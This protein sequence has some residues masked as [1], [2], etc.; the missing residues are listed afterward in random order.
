MRLLSNSFITQD[1]R[2]HR[3]GTGGTHHFEEPMYHEDTQKMYADFAAAGNRIVVMDN[4]SGAANIVDSAWHEKSVL[5]LGQE[6]IGV[7]PAS[8]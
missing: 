1:A 2:D 7:H 4:I 5:V 3:R 6:S 8:A